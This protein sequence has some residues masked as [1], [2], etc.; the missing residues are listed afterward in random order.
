[1]RIV[2]PYAV[3]LRCQHGGDVGN[4][5]RIDGAHRVLRLFPMRQQG[6]RGEHRQI[7]FKEVEQFRGTPFGQTRPSPEERQ[8][9]LDFLVQELRR[10]QIDEGKGH[11]PADRRVT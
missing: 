7:A 5:P 8:V 1:M 11:D 9:P 2:R 3:G 4:V 10:E 6:L